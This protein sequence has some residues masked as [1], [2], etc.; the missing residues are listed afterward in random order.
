GCIVYQ[1]QVMQI[2]REIAGYTFGHADVVR[3]AISKKK[4]GVLEKEREA[5]LEGAA[6]NGMAEADAVALFEDIVSFANYAF[7]KSHA[8]AYGVL[9]FRTAYLRTHYPREYNCALL[10]SV[11]SQTGKLTEYITEC[12][13]RGIAVLPPDI[14][15]SRANFHVEGGAIRF[16]LVALKN[17]GLSFINAVVAERDTHGPFMD[18]ADFVERMRPVELN[19]RQVE[20]L[21]KSGAMDNLGVYRSQLLTVYEN[22]LDSHAHAASRSAEGQIGMF[23][24]STEKAPE[25]RTVIEYPQIPEYTT[26]EKLSLEK[27][28]CGFYLSGHILDDYSEQL[29][30]I[31]TDHAGDIL[32]AFSESDDGDG[33]YTDKKLVTLAGCVTRRTNKITKNGDP[34]AFIMLDDGTGE[35]ELVCFPKKLAEWGHLLQYDAAVIVKGAIS[36]RDD[37]DIKILA[38]QVTPMTA[39]GNFA[40]KEPESLIGSDILLRN[41]PEE[42]PPVPQAPEGNMAA[43]EPAVSQKPKNPKIFLRVD[44]KTGDACRRLRAFCRI[45]PG[46]VPVLFYYKDTGTYEKEDIVCTFL[47]DFTIREMQEICGEENLVIR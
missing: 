43:A 8:A 13:H 11:L 45:F 28:S 27:E 1:E 21:I 3:R 32:K 9:S 19:K 16:G 34:M 47:N 40:G 4:Q 39:N 26:R 23:D 22:V 2:F 5:F 15:K 41:T 46:P 35:I 42:L 30:A 29:A 7:N 14:N 33:T 44:S 20:F 37:E 38:N 17:V 12:S 6:K 31:R 25:I 24:D 36:A 10:T 18:F